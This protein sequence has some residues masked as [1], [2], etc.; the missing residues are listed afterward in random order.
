MI[1]S[2]Q[3]PSTTM[4]TPPVSPKP[5]RSVRRY[6]SDQYNKLVR[7]HSRSPS[8][9]S[10]KASGSGAPP[11]SPPP[12]T[13]AGFLAPPSDTQ[14]AQLH[15]SH[16]DSQL[17]MGPKLESETSPI[18]TMWTGL[19]S[20]FEEL[21]KAARPF[22]LLQST[23][24]SFIPCLGLLEATAKNRKE[25]GEIALDLKDLGESLTQHMEQTR[26]ARMSGCI[27]NVLM[28]IEQLAAL[29]KEK[30]SRGTGR[31]LLEARADE[32]EVIGYYRK[33]E[34]LFRRFQADAT[35]SASSI[36]EELLVNS[37][38]ERLTPAKLANYDSNLSSGIGRR[39][40]TEGTRT[41]IMSEMDDWS[42]NPK[43]PDLYLMSG[44]AGTGKTTIAYSFA[45]GLEERKQLAA[46]FFCTRTSPKCRN[47]NLIIPTIAYQLARYS[48]PFQS[49]L[50][51][52]LG[53][54]P[55]IGT[56]NI[57]KQ[58]ERLLKE[59]LLK[60]KDAIPE[61]TVVVIDA[62]D[63]CDD[64]H[65]V[66]LVL[67]LIFRH[68]SNL[69][70]KFFV[71]SRPEPEIYSKMATQT[72]TSR[73]IL[74]LHEIEKSLVQA[75]IEL[76]LKEELSTVTV[77]EAEIVE[78]ATRSGNLFIY[79]AT[80]VRYIQ[81]LDGC[82]DPQLRL[83]SALAIK[84]ESTNKY[85]EVDALY[86]AVV[87][88][89][90]ERK[91]LDSGEASNV[92]A[93]LWTVLCAQEPIGVATLATLSGINDTARTLSALQPLRSVVHLSEGNGLVSTLHASFPDFMFSKDRS[94]PYFCD[95]A[96]SHQLVA[97]RCFEVMKDQLRFNICSLESSF[98]PDSK[99]GDLESRI[100]KAI[101]P[102][103][104]YA[105][106]YWAD[107]LGFSTNSTHL[108]DALQ[109]FLSLRLLFWIEVLSLKRE[110]IQ[111]LGTLVK[112]KKW[113][114]A[115]SSSPN[116][117]RF[118]EDAHNFL[119][120]YAANPVSQFT[121]HIYISSL[122][123]CPR[124]S[125]VYKKYQS[126][127]R[128]LIGLKGP[129][130]D[131]LETIALAT[132]A[133]GSPV[134]SVSYSSDGSKVAFGC[135]DGT[136]GVRNAYDGS[137]ITGPFKG[138]SDIVLSVAF[139]P[140]GTRFVSGSDDCMIKIWNAQD[141][142]LIGEP[143]QGHTDG[144]NSVAFS[145][146]GRLIASASADMTVRVWSV[147]KG[148]SVAGPFMGHT[149]WVL[150]VAF[151]PDGL[152]LVSGSYDH[153]VR[154]WNIQDG[155]LAFDPLEGHTGPVRSVAFSPDGTRIASGSDD[156][157]IRIWNAQDGL[158][159]IGSLKGH[160]DEICSVAFS[161]DGVRLVSSSMDDT[162]RIWSSENGNLVAGPLEGHTNAIHSIAFSPDGTRI[163][164]GSGDRTIRVWNAVVDKPILDQCKGYS[165][166]IT[167]IALPRNGAYIASASLVSIYVWD[168]QNGS[169]IAGPFEGHTGHI[170]SIALSP[171]GAQLVSG[172]DDNTVRVWDVKK[173]TLL[174]GPFKDHSKA[175]A[176][177]AFSPDGAYIASGAVDQT[178]YVRN[179][180]DGTLIAPPF[181]GHTD[182][183]RSVAFSPDSSRLI[184][185]SDDHTIRLWDIRNHTLATDP[186]L[187]HTDGVNSV[188]FSPCGQYAVSGSRDHTI[189]VWNVQSST[190]INDPFTGHTDI[191]RS[192]GFSPKG[193]CIVSGSEDRTVRVWHTH[194]GAL[195]AGPFFGHVNIVMSVAFFPDSTRIVS[196]SW[197]ST[198]RIWGLSDIPGIPSTSKYP[199]ALPSSDLAHSATP[200][201]DWTVKD[202]GWI[203][204]HDGNVLFWASPEVI[205]RLL[206]PH[207]SSII[208]R[209]GTIEVDMS[210]ALFGECWKDRHEEAAWKQKLQRMA[211]ATRLPSL[212]DYRPPSTPKS[213][214]RTSVG[215]ALR[216]RY[217][218]FSGNP[219]DT[220]SQL[221]SFNIRSIVPVDFNSILMVVGADSYRET[222]SNLRNAILDLCWDE[223]NLAFYG[224]NSM[225]GAS[226]RP[227]SKKGD[228][229]ILVVNFVLNS[230]NGTFPSTFL[231]SE[232]QWDFPIM[233]PFLFYELGLIELQS[234]PAHN[235]I[236]LETLNNVPK[237]LTKHDPPQFNSTVTTFDLIPDGQLGI[238]KDQLPKQ[239]LAVGGNASPDVNAQ[240][241][242]V[243]NGGMAGK[244][245]S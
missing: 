163:I 14:T 13:V 170:R 165:N 125:L 212:K 189:R 76:Y 132:W 156:R 31:R 153:T 62:L 16:S 217:R 122:A 44:M 103:L 92:R 220:M 8:Q 37:R 86:G 77:T 83:E 71:T 221:R 234:W 100:T 3:F 72:T 107:H 18:I 26:S 137:P 242:T 93:V 233:G 227:C 149:S 51:E 61:N 54:D 133:I 162:I 50:C 112:A 245:E 47:A 197:D 201:M 80:L 244:G 2:W 152:R 164:S 89:A 39:T 46:S 96:E 176:S 237:E 15:H 141:G 161:P 179:S 123:L 116:L 173:A 121:P 69:P 59:P 154:V 175:V 25:Y 45:T 231:E 66:R 20:A 104:S 145:L 33:I 160:T 151:S 60:V 196:G 19:R 108:S 9:Q 21:R 119:T 129:G 38:L 36:T 35:L 67:D 224:Y 207:C 213:W 94:G 130:L 5:K 198:I 211:S 110:T 134:R 228:P 181:T 78:L 97:R 27:E 203:M 105:C 150:S 230:Y 90:L 171:G 85:A 115:T 159:V 53:K 98:V 193:E 182:T 235:Y 48:N 12:R 138:H 29:I 241:G 215:I 140:D 166:G 95:P 169:C 23:I 192:V 120:G 113:L 205:Q 199:P 243:V 232:F 210:T 106:R 57:V 40:C 236:I 216:K 102:P 74:H 143:F 208:S 73:T 177:V 34:R 56:R 239:A 240:G 135:R 187:G 24:D 79:A 114:G 158:L 70:L 68:V 6:I 209:F 174:A 28:G 238:T 204:N 111:G 183:V 75:D 4:A 136:V 101:S 58:F 206:T 87:K 188:A 223:N 194:G 226:R 7:S 214:G 148:A 11:A 99:V 55:D 144:I 172:S 131:Q 168:T 41:K 63:E 146:D 139:S 43:G 22:P 30:E 82:V 52:I 167:S 185:G 155:T 219:N 128:G 190:L 109:G 65:A 142:S 229:S 10:I 49:A 126:C 157:S 81:P 184:S 195:M 118:V 17:S 200:P 222:A 218:Q 84:S 64:R 42:H 32:E 147:N 88:A 178:V 124:S 91:G 117:A 186:F 127:I 225:A 180:S 191:V 1:T 202:D